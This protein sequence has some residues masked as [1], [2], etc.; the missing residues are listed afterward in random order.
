VLAAAGGGLGPGGATLVAD[1]AVAAELWA[2]LLAEAR[3]RMAP[4]SEAG[5]SLALCVRCLTSFAS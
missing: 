4:W 1:E 3:A 2:R 5:G